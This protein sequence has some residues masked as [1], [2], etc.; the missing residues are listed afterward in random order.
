VD[1]KYNLISE[2]RQP[3][4]RIADLNLNKKQFRKNSEP[5]TN[6]INQKSKSETNL[7]KIDQVPIKIKKKFNSEQL[8]LPNINLKSN[9]NNI[10]KNKE[11]SENMNKHQNNES[12]SP[13]IDINKSPT[14]VYSSPNIKI[15]E[16]KAKK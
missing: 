15:D 9:E 3:Y 10:F 6:K 12:A 4:F 7:F 5:G 1:Y 8:K 13:R 11:I 14:R 16:S 2:Q